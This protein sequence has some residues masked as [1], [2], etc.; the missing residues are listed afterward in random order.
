MTMNEFPYWGVI[1]PDFLKIGN[2][3]KEKVKEARDWCLN[4]CEDK[5]ISSD[6]R[7]W[8]FLNEQDAIEFQKRYGGTIKFKDRG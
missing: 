4:N 2:F 3:T 7:P 8:A 6:I 5:F 1:L